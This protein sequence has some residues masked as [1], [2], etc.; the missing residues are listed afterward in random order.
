LSGRRTFAETVHAPALFGTSARIN[1]WA[2][3]LAMTAAGVA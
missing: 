3:E 2:L 1:E